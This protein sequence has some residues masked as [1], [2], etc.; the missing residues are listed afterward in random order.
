MTPETKIKKATD[1]IL[2]ALCE[3]AGIGYDKDTFGPFLRNGFPDTRY[4]LGSVAVFAELKADG[5]KLRKLQKIEKERHESLNYV[6][7]E[8]LGSSGVDNLYR[9]LRTFFEPD[10]VAHRAALY[11]EDCTAI[12]KALEK[13]THE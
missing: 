1:K 7:I 13:L 8:I 9:D 12:Y 11:I 4:H 6:A 3:E 10:A 2:K 5:K